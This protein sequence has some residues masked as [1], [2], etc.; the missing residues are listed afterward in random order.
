MSLRKDSKLVTAREPATTG[1][2]LF[3]N[4]HHVF[5]VLADR[6]V[7]QFLFRI[8]ANAAAPER[9]CAVCTCVSGQ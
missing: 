1:S 7:R 3:V 5:Q 9:C 8:G 4:F 2:L 6:K